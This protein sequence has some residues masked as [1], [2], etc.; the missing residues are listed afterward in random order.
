MDK[1]KLIPPVLLL[2][3][4]LSAQTTSPPA[5][6]RDLTGVWMLRNPESMRAFAGATYTKAEP[7][8]TPWAAEKYKLAKSSNGGQ[9]TLETTNDPVLTKCDP[10]GLPRVYFHPYPFEFVNTPTYTLMLY[11]YDHVVR[12]IYTDGRPIPKEP[13]P[14]WMGYSVGHWDGD[15]TFVVDTV[16]FNEK[17]WLDRLGHVHSDQLHVTERFRRV[18]RDHMQIDITMQDPK[19]LAKPWTTTFYSE[20]RPKWELGEISCAGDYLEFNKFEK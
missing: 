6:K 14:S 19:A 8:L 3:G 15:T 9:Y 16:G 12:R 5:P 7:E 13:D 11:E 17:T 2:T 20:L 10:P 4:A 18:D 1:L